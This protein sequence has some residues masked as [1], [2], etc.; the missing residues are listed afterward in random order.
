M[1]N[2]LNF[3]LN[4]NLF[5]NDNQKVFNLILTYKKNKKKII[6]I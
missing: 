5:Y 3:L 1:Y 4:N 2:F 6:T